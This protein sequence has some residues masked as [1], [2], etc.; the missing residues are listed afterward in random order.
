VAAEAATSVLVR[1]QIATPKLAALLRVEVGPDAS[2]VI[3]PRSGPAETCRVRAPASARPTGPTACA[4]PPWSVAAAGVEP[5]GPLDPLALRAPAVAARAAA[6]RRTV[7][8]DDA[9][10]KLDPRAV[11]DRLLDY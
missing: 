4:D 5:G 8:H 6:E 11:G 3:R 2:R 1:L 10:A 9:A 7:G